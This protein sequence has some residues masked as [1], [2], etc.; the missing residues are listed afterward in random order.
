MNSA[1]EELDLIR[2]ESIHNDFRRPG[3]L[4][5]LSSIHPKHFWCQFND[6]KGVE[7]E[8]V[9]GEIRT[10]GHLGCTWQPARASSDCAPTP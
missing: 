7:D 10:I 5:G 3:G 2:F 4:Q 9:L 8:V 1:F 6:H